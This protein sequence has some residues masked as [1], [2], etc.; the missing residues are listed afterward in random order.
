ML[1][2][3]LFPICRLPNTSYSKHLCARRFDTIFSLPFVNHLT[4]KRRVD[5]KQHFESFQGGTNVARL[6]QWGGM[7]VYNPDSVVGLSQSPVYCQCI[8]R[9]GTD[10]T[11]IDQ[12]GH[13]I[14]VV[15]FNVWCSRLGRTTGHLR[16]RWV[17]HWGYRQRM[18]REVTEVSFLPFSSSGVNL[19]NLPQRLCLPQGLKK[20]I[21]KKFGPCRLAFVSIFT[22]FDDIVEHLP[23]WFTRQKKQ[24][25]RTEPVLNHG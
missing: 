3:S 11:V 22:I 18:A 12:H 21:W 17:C 24:R 6:Y 14:R 8:W 20:L 15:T 5:R 7:G 23:L 10:R 9:S 13:F 16:E 19:A 1:L 25:T 4:I 2:L